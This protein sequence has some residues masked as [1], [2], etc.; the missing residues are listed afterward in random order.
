MRALALLLVPQLVSAVAIGERN[1][2]PLAAYFINNDPAGNHIV[3]LQISPFDGTVSKP[4]QVPTGGKG[5][6]GLTAG[7]N[8]GPPTNDVGGK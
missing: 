6:I 4:V 2:D 3:S 1:F 7:T 8:G 5:A